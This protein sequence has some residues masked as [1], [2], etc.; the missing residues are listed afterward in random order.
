[1]R[2]IPF[3][4][5]A[6]ACS[7]AEVA[8]PPRDS[9]GDG[10]TDEEEAAPGL[11][12]AAADSDGDGWADGEE[13]AKN[14]DP[15]DVDRHPYLGG[16]PIDACAAAMDPSETGVDPGDVAPPFALRDQFGETVHLYDFCDHVVW[17]TVCTAAGASCHEPLAPTQETWQLNWAD[18]LMVVWLWVADVQGGPVETGDLAGLAEDHGVTF[19]M[20]DDDAY[21]YSEAFEAY[22]APF[23]ILIGRGGVVLDNSGDA[24]H[25]EALAAATD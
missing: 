2:A 8:A 9:D 3:L 25:D 18:G 10:L 23:S 24:T 5:V 14:A 19:P 12:P 1:M 6:L 13:V 21:E 22:Q 20:L 11:D 16:W 7:S 15:L 17:L 4:L